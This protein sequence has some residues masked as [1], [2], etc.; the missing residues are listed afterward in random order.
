VVPASSDG[1]V[2]F[3]RATQRTLS[4]RVDQTLPAPGRLVASP[5]GERALAEWLFPALAAHP[6]RKPALILSAGARSVRMSATS[7]RERRRR[8]GH[9]AGL[10][11]T[12]PAA[13]GG[14]HG[15]GRSGCG[16]RAAGPCGPQPPRGRHGEVHADNDVQPSRRN[17]CALLVGSPPSVAASQEA[18]RSRWGRTARPIAATAR[19]G[20]WLHRRGSP[21]SSMASPTR[22][23]HWCDRLRSTR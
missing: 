22:W 11:G 2:T 8:T 4:A 3:P 9:S 19:C 21:S 5:N 15:C 12:R 20:W 10:G 7:R 6:D 14:R 18:A 23:Q 13:A 1:H 16:R 17:R